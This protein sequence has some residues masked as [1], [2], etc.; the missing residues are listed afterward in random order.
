MKYRIYPYN[1]G[2][3]SATV[4]KQELQGLKVFPDRNYHP[5]SDHLIVN[6]GMG[7]TPDWTEERFLT[8]AKIL[9][10]PHAVQRAGNKIF[11]LRDMA[12]GSA[13]TVEWTVHQCEAEK[14]LEEGYKVI[15]RDAVRG[16]SGVGIRMF[17]GDPA[18]LYTKYIGLRTEY[19][20]H[21]FN[22]EV[23]CVQQKRR[24]HDVPDDQVN[25]KVR[26]TAGGFIYAVND[27]VPLSDDS[28]KQ[29]KQAIK[30]LH[31]DFGAVDLIVPRDSDL[32]YVLEVNTAPG[33]ESPTV[34]QAY[35]KAIKEAS[36]T[37]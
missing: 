22:D 33:L 37:V 13:R 23:I 31:L 35:I 11:A 3:R 36:C 8:G 18:P 12:N 1:T 34:I 30:D 5:R 4:L 2:S 14:W 32:G 19:R 6:W 10:C 29:C 15:A 20:V 27:I 25:W 16:H 7:R 17:E 28:I 26:N 24:A 21:V 9:N